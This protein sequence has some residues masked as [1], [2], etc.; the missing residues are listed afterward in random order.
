MEPTDTVTDAEIIEAIN[1]WPVTDGNE[2]MYTSPTSR[3]H[4]P[5]SVSSFF[6]RNV[7]K[8]K[9]VA[10]KP[11]Y[12]DAEEDLADVALAKWWRKTGKYLME[13]DSVPTSSNP[14]TIINFITGTDEGLHFIKTEISRLREKISKG[15]KSA[16]ASSALSSYYEKIGNLSLAKMHLESAR[17][18]N[19]QDKE[20]EWR[21]KRL[22]RAVH[23]R[24]KQE[25]ILS[26]LD[27]SSASVQSLPATKQVERVPADSLSFK[28]FFYKYEL[29][30]T[31]VVI[32]GLVDKMTTVP[33]TLQHISDVAGNC[34]V[35][36]KK[37]IKDSVQWAR[38]EDATTMKVKDFIS[39]LH[40]NL[41]HDQDKLYLFDWNIPLH[42]QELA[43]ELKIPKYFA[44]DF[45]QRTAQG[46]LYKD[47]WP[48]L[49]IAPAGLTSE[50]HVDAFGS[51]FWMAL[52]EG[53]KR[54]VFFDKDD[55]AM[56]Y[57]MFSHPWSTDPVFQ[58]DLQN[59]DL[60]QHPLLSLTQ[61]I[62]CVLQPGELLFVPAGCPHRVENLETSLAISG[63]FVDL[64][65]FHLVKEEL[66]VTSLIDE[67]SAELLKQFSDPDFKSNMCSDIDHLSW[68]QFK[69]WP[70]ED[71]EKFDIKPQIVEEG[72]KTLLNKR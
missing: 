20:L 47:S 44:G 8:V 34:S 62:E 26:Q 10:E 19:P 64:S 25:E 18:K 35:T 42:C 30:S 66:T 65:N 14:N 3:I 49:F 40:S 16:N 9:K 32:T 33:W 70:A 67:R 59:P 1:E 43:A 45:L 63:N 60:K 11:V 39:S 5:A 22:K 68:E 31:P 4:N 36:L 27:Y 21:F 58:V 54:W 13:S 41:S 53:S 28:D 23:Y 46:S 24:Q 57:P 61:P 6:L 69:T 7:G 56:L 50:L 12:D 37:C 38:L 51:N 15:C 48:S 55:V 2:N 52:F 29:T 17:D 72:R 71:Y